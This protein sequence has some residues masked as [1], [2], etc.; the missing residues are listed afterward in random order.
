M[1]GLQ[2]E[3]WYCIAL[4]L[5]AISLLRLRLQTES[6]SCIFAAGGVYKLE[7]FLPEDYPMAAPK[8]CSTSTIWHTLLFSFR[9]VMQLPRR[10]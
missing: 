5:A 10:L 4:Y 8:V 9:C 3:G 7:L 1:E 6:E 2:L